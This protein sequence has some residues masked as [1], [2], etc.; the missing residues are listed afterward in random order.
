[1]A[2]GAVLQEQRA[3]LFLEKLQRFLSAQRWGDRREEGHPKSDRPTEL[4]QG[5]QEGTHTFIVA[6]RLMELKHFRLQCSKQPRGNR[7]AS[8]LA[9]D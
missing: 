5:R 7:V 9:D 8:E 4:G 3:D 1:M 2:L 6:N